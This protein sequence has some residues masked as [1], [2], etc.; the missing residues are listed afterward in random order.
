MKQ[1]NNQSKDFQKY[2]QEIESPDYDGP[3]I[4]QVLPANT[5]PTDKAI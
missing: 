2:L 1:N 5:S 3:D 4:S